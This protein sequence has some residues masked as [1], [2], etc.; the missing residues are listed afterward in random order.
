MVSG[1]RSRGHR[2]ERGF[3]GARALHTVDLVKTWPTVS[4]PA[5]PG[6]GAALRIRDT[7]SGE[8]VEIPVNGMKIEKPLRLVCRREASLS[9]AAKSFL[10]IVRGDKK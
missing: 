3:A 7:A 9:H 5:I 6:A 10:E 1:R 8:L 2:S 4:I